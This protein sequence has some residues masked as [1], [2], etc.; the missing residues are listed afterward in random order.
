LYLDYQMVAVAVP[1]ASL[2]AKVSPNATFLTYGRATALLRSRCFVSIAYNTRDA[3]LC[4]RLPRAGSFPHVI[5]HY[6]SVEGCAK[7]VAI[8]R[9]PGFD[10]G[11]LTYGFMPFAHASDFADA[12]RDIG[13]ASEAVSRAATPK[14]RE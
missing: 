1:D 5:D 12:L 2:C 10:S 9:R 7:N 4:D 3:A 11:G 6:D 8:Y 14:E 13:Y